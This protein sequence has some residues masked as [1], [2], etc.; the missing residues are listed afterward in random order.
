MW[1]RLLQVTGLK[2][3]STP[4]KAQSSFISDEYVSI[5]IE[6]LHETMTGK[7]ETDIEPSYRVSAP[8]PRKKSLSTLFSALL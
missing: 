8:S 7:D 3:I 4:N 2:Q 6:P 5:L 1:K